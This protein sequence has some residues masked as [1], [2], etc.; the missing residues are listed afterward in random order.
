VT[1]RAEL[2]PRDRKGRWAAIPGATVRGGKIRLRLVVGSEPHKQRTRELIK[3]G[4][5]MRIGLTT[6]KPYEYPY[7]GPAGSHTVDG[8]TY[9]A[10][11]AHAHS[12]SQGLPRSRVKKRARGWV[13]IG[14]NGKPHDATRMKPFKGNT[15]SDPHGDID[16]F[17]RTIPKVREDAMDPKVEQ[18]LRLIERED[19]LAELT[20]V[21]AVRRLSEAKDSL[22]KASTPEP[23][24]TS[25]TSNWV[26]RGGGLPAYVQH[27]AHDLMEKRGKTE[28]EAIQMAIGIVKRWA[29][30]GGNVDAN[31]RA[32]AAKAVAEWTALKAKAHAK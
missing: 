14:V 21:Q 2:H 28:S 6:P 7:T 1:F 23:F 25:K 10:S 15:W 22:M 4:D 13:V 26:A 3:R 19:A 29:R 24:S 18:K 27:I 11:E 8:V 20:A 9:F 12:V 5:T 31:T 30:G 16:E 32:A 17:G